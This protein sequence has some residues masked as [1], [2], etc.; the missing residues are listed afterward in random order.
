VA[1][2]AE[3]ALAFALAAGAPIGV[4]DVAETAVGTAA[5]EDELDDEAPIGKLL[6]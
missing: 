5:A 4:V 3:T 6:I 2:G 1:H